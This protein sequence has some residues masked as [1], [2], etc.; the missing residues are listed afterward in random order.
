MHARRMQFAP[1]NSLDNDPRRIRT[2]PLFVPRLSGSPWKTFSR[3]RKKKEKSRGKPRNQ[4]L[5]VFVREE[6]ETRLSLEI[7]FTPLSRT[8]SDV[9]IEATQLRP[10]LAMTNFIAKL[11]K[12]TSREI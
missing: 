3:E 6:K 10:T 2:D 4:E 12:L 5:F 9:A 1:G 11:Y 8:P 7:Q